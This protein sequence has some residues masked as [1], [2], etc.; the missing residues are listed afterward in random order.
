MPLRGW[1]ISFAAEPQFACL[2]QAADQ[3]KFEARHHFEAPVGN[4]S[5]RQQGVKLS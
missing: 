3:A 1:L 5:E 4:E 2:Y